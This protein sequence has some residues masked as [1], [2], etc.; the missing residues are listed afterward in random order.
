VGIIGLVAHITERGVWKD[1]RAFT[2][3]Y[4]EHIQAIRKNRLFLYFALH[5]LEEG[6]SER[7]KI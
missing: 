7:W 6:S 5:I 1:L 4:R 2:I 3:G